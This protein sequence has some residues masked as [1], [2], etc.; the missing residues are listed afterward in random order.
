LNAEALDNNLVVVASKYL[1][2]HPN[3]TFRVPYNPLF[4][5]PN[6]G[7]W[8]DKRVVEEIKFVKCDIPRVVYVNV[9]EGDV[10]RLYRH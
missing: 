1:S 9:E 4:N 2:H 10:T 6:F 8:I 7:I 3:A 5:P